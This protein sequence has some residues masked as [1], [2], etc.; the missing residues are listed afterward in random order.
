MK[1]VV[2]S[3]Y[4]YPDAVGGS[5][6]F[7]HDVAQRLAARGHCCWAVSG[8]PGDGRPYQERIGAVDVFRYPI[9][10]Q[11]HARSFVSRL[12]GSYRAMR[13]IARQTPID[14]IH[15]HSPIGAIGAFL[16]PEARGAIGRPPAPRVA[17]IHGTG[18]LSEY[19]CEVAGERHRTPRE[20]LYRAAID[21]VEREYLRR[22]CWI[23]A[24]SRFSLDAF[25]AQHRLDPSRASII[26][27]GVDLERFRPGPRD[28]A[29]RH[30]GLPAHRPILLTVRRLTARMGLDLLL[31]AARLVAQQMPEALFLIGGTGPLRP[32]LE[33]LITRMQLEQNVSLLGFISEIELPLYYQAADLFVL[34]SIASEGFGL[35]TLEALACDLPVLGTPVGATVELLSDFDPEMLFADTTPEAMA[36]QI[37]TWLGRGSE[38]ACYRARVVEQF[39]WD[40]CMDRM[41]R[42]LT[43]VASA[44][45]SDQRAPV[46]R[47]GAKRP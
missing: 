13:Q 36:A 34:P 7:A 19:L 44:R 47:A 31:R 8:H 20:R 6:N 1:I 5:W 43:A 14:L 35:I 32:D 11:N 3:D 30:L 33:R 45:S 17:T 2:V 23:H 28:E 9:R 12:A 16:S 29:R 25:A 26:P 37:V 42:L 4:L 40:A 46:G 15:S 41:E 38:H 18:V 21:R 10:R 22:A 39:S 24:L 27:P